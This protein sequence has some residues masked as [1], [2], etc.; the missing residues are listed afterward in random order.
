VKLE[1][2]ILVS[3]V[4]VVLASCAPSVQSYDPFIDSQL[5]CDELAI[6]ITKTR[7]LKAEAQANKGLSGQNVAWALVFWPAIFANEANNSEAI[8][9]ADER[10]FH[11]YRYY[12]AKECSTPL[13]ELS[14]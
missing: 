7:S 14:D 13:G 6:E 3:V 11:L 12:E 1:L 10:L 8:R 5:S 2:A 4:A 9:A